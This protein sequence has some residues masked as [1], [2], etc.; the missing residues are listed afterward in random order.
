MWIAVGAL[1]PPPMAEALT[2][3]ETEVVQLA[4]VADLKREIKD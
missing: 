1:I 4:A 3:R 2:G